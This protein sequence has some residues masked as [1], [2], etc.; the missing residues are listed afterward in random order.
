MLNSSLISQNA[1]TH[2]EVAFSKR[3][4][5][6]ISFQTGVTLKDFKR[7]L[8]VLGTRPTVIAERGGIKK[9]LAETLLQAFASCPRQ[10]GKKR[11]TRSRLGWIS[12][13]T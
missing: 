7:A 2:L 11:A 5:G 10:S 3:E 9:F 13:P 6:A 4:I 12:G 1:L 8:A